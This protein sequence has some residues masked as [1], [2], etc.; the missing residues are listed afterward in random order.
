MEVTVCAVIVV[1]GP[2]IEGTV[3]VTE[4]RTGAVVE[5]I[6]VREEQSGVSS[7]AVVAGAAVAG[8]SSSSSVPRRSQDL[9][10]FDRELLFIIFEGL[11]TLLSSK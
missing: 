7:A 1:L 4:E 3:V 9:I 8:L 6:G 5:F 2:L 11:L 10:E